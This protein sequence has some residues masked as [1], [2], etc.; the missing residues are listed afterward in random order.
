[1]PSKIG[2]GLEGTYWTKEH[3]VP[4]LVIMACLAVICGF[5]VFCVCGSKLKTRTT[6]Y[7]LTLCQVGDD[8]LTILAADG[9]VVD[10]VGAA[11]ATGIPVVLRRTK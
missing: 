10:H 4:H 7:R 6:E 9:W 8:Q 3:V 1:M 2:R 5:S 11:T